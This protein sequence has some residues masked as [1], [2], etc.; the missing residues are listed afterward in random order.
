MPS[1]ILNS[2]IPHSILFSTHPTYCLAHVFRCICFVDIPRHG[3]DKLCAKWCVWL[4]GF[5]NF[6]GGKIVGAFFPI[7]NSINLFSKTSQFFILLTNI[8]NHIDIIPPKFYHHYIPLINKCRIKNCFASPK[9]YHNYI[10]LLYFL[11]ISYLVSLLISYLL[12]NQLVILLF[13]YSV[14]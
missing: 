14:D 7:D 4:Y 13:C 9:L 12:F 10:P 11:K 6:G 5:W 8:N 3:Q 1:S 2:R